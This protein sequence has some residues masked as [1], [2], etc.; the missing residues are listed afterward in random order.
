M[1]VDAGARI[2]VGD[3]SPSV[4][5]DVLV[6]LRLRDLLVEGERSGVVTPA[7]DGRHV[8]EVDAARFGPFGGSFL[9]G[10]NQRG[11]AV[12]DLRAVAEQQTARDRRDVLA[13]VEVCLDVAQPLA[14]LR[15]GIALRVLVVELGQTLQVRG[16]EAVTVVVDVAEPPEELGEGQFDALSLQLVPA[17]G[18]EEVAALDGAD[19]LHLLDTEDKGG[20]VALGLELGRGHQDGDAARGAGGLVAGGGQAAEVGVDLSEEAAELSL[21]GVELAGEVA[22]V[23]GVDVAGFHGGN[24]ER[25]VDGLSHHVAQVVLFLAPVAG[26]VGLVSA[27]DVGLG[28]VNSFG[29]SRRSGYQQ[30]TGRP[31]CRRTAERRSAPRRLQRR[32]RNPRRSSSAAC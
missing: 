31:A 28:H 1:A 12:G 11:G 18:A 32:C 23:C 27:E 13:V 21:F 25:A 26:E 19:G 5:Q 14:G 15:G 6:A 10:Q 4:G 9:V 3:G 17:G 8:G 29:A 20:A 24:V 2:G 16:V 22:D 30:W 7:L